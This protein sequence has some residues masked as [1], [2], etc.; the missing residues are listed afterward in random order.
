LSRCFQRLEGFPSV[1]S[2][3]PLRVR[4]HPLLSLTSP[5][6]YVLLVT[7]PTP[8]LGR[9]PSLGS[10][11]PSRQKRLESTQRRVSHTRL[12]SALSVSHALDGLLLHTPCG[13]VSSHCHVRDSLF[14]G[15]LRCQAGSPHRRVVPSCRYR[16]SPHGELP[17]RCQFHSLRLQGFDPSSDPLRPTGGLDLPSAR[18]PL[19]LSLLR[20]YLRL[21][22]RRLHVPSAHDLSRLAL[23]VYL[24]AGLQRINQQPT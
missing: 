24:T 6:E 20:A 12:R 8:L 3:V 18:S 16:A 14:R 2:P 7:C 5:S 22:W 4:V 23:A 9:A 1:P 11:S 21:P 19:G 15:F 10:A 17:R 13:P